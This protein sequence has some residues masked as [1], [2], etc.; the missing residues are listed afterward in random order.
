MYVRRSSKDG[1]FLG[2]LEK[3]GL[4]TYTNQVKTAK[5]FIVPVDHYLK[6]HR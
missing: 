4:E 2:A 5:N 1:H 6:L 3:S